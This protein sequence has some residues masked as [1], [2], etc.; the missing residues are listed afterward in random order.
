MAPIFVESDDGG[1]DSSD[2]EDWQ[3]LCRQRRAREQRA[4]GDAF[5]ATAAASHR[6]RIGGAAAAYVLHKPTQ[7][8][9]GVKRKD[10]SPFI[11]RDHVARLTPAEFKLRYR[12]TAPVFNSLVERIEPH[13]SV[14]DDLQ[15]IR[16]KGAVIEPSTKLAVCLR[17]LAG[18]QI[19]DLQLIYH[20]SK[21]VCYKYVWLGIDAIN[22]T[23]VIEFPFGNMEKLKVLPATGPTCT[24]LPVSHLA[25]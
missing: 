1:W 10:S 2:N 5:L 13:L 3:A 25:V 12:L 16:S 7:G 21:S 19:L 14:K 17:F 20:L 24:T 22:N 9:Q 18:G 23:I 8:P 4:Q 15:A 11:W 6:K